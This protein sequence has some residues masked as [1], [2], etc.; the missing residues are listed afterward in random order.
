M[1]DITILLSVGLT[2]NLIA[3]IIVFSIKDHV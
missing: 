3:L 2:L 1:D